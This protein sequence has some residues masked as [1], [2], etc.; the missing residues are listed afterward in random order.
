MLIF[1]SVSGEIIAPQKRPNDLKDDSFPLGVFF[2][3]VM[4][5]RVR[6]WPVN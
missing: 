5:F 3:K 2:Y 4:R 1:Y 6:L